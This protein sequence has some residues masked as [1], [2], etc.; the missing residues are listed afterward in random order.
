MA[1]TAALFEGN[2]RRRWR[3]LAPR[4]LSLFN[5]DMAAMRKAPAT[6]FC[7]FLCPLPMTFPPLTGLPGVSPSHEVKSS[8][9]GNAL[10]FV[11]ISETIVCAVMMLIP[12]M[13]H[14]FTPQIRSSSASR[15]RIV[16]WLSLAFPDFF[17]FFA[18]EPF[19]GVANGTLGSWLR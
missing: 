16:G 13:V 10:T 15:F 8:S 1:F 19:V 2:C 3:Y 9:E 7:T 11:P 14:R 4:Q 6:R 17:G 12:S 5:S 18:G